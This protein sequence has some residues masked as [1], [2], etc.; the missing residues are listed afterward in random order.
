MNVIHEVEIDNVEV[1]FLA[2][3]CPVVLGV[4]QESVIRV[5]GDT[6]ASFTDV[7]WQVVY[8]RVTIDHQS[9][10]IPQDLY[11][12]VDEKYGDVIGDKLWELTRSL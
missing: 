1:S 5:C 11:D 3:P 7:E 6:L 2:S 10:I 9:Y 8:A 12:E 4:E